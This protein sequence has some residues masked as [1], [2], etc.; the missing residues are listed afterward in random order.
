[1]IQIK[2]INI[3]RYIYIVLTMAKTY[4]TIEINNVLFEG[5]TYKLPE[6][7]VKTISEL[8]KLFASTISASTI[9]TST[10]NPSNETSL[11]PKSYERKPSSRSNGGGGGGSGSTLNDNDWSAVRTSFK[12]TKMD[13]KEGIEKDVNTIR[14]S[15][16]K[17][18]AKN[19]ESQ[20]NTI[21]EFIEK[22]IETQESAELLPQECSDNIRR[23]GH[24]IFDIA[25]TN[26]NSSWQY[27][28]LYAELVK[29]FT[30]FS[31]ILTE[32]ID[33]FKNTITTIQYTDPAV[34][35]DMYC[36]YTKTNDARKSTSEFLMNLVKLNIVRNATIIDII[37]Y[38][39]RITC[40]YIL[41]TDK[42]HEVEEII[43]NVF[44][45]VTTG[46]DQLKMDDNWREIVDNITKLSVIKPKQHPSM[47]SRAVFK[48]MDTLDK[49]NS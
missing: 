10:I 23:I 15:L 43:E 31:Q 5:F 29:R 39:Q 38:F 17:I 40:Q 45:F 22:F 35:Y 37:R 47:T 41:E 14:S 12:T 21:I 36:S 42:I 27:A 6:P 30:V 20:R 13:V 24:S 11:K 44:I 49:I 3:V 28:E 19:Y 1:M 33:N 2:N 34:N 25:S 48:C 16:N 26:K 8:D 4:S 32:F 7:I 18:S 9:N 46:M